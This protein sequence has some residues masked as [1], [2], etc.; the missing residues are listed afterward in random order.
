L[1]NRK[2]L[3]VG[4][5]IIGLS[6]AEALSRRG[7]KPILL[8]K[9]ELGREASWAGAG[10]LSLKKAVLAGGVQLELSVFSLRLFERWM[11]LIQQ[12]SGVDPGYHLG[13][14]LEIAFEE[15]EEAKLR[16]LFSRLQALKMEVAWKTGEEVRKG[17]SEISTEVISAIQMP[18][19]GVI[20]PPR[21]LRA[22]VTLLAKRGVVMQDQTVVSG[23]LVR[24]GKVC[25][26][27]TAFEEIGADAVV[28]AAGAWSGPLGDHLGIKL[29]VRPM[30][31][32]VAMFYS[33]RVTF[34]SSLTT[35]QISIVPRGDGHYHAS[36]PSED[37]GFNKNTTL[38]GVEAI[39]SGAYRVAPG[40][41]LAKME[42][43]WAGLLPGSPDGKPFLGTV[44]GIEG[45]YL[46]C[47]HFDQ[48]Y[49]L[50]PATGLLIEQTLR[51]EEP[52]IPMEPFSLNR[53]IQESF[54][55]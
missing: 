8:E 24:G 35:S 13:P 48:G 17:E 23:F 42:S 32:Q 53:P 41:R 44:P 14:T 3:I 36:I 11:G 1:G 4:G 47:G 50:A 22:L 28:L 33:D 54:E 12:E 55:M 27:K 31:G 43:R 38:Q 10:S 46:A 19:T 51:G 29:P 39:E 25:G 20:R 16:N 26:V 21:L 30:R 9:G 18:K 37:A 40:L 52:D 5:G 7:L 6:I 15:A 34:Q 2:I 49:L 45:L